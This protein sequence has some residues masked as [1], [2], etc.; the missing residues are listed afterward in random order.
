MFTPSFDQKGKIFTEVISKKP[1]QVFI[2]TEKHIIIG[3]I[4]I[5]PDDRLKDEIN[6]NEQFLAVTNAVIKDFE[7]NTQFKT[8]FVAVNRQHVSWVLP[9]DE[10]TDTT[11]KSWINEIEG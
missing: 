7:G 5:R 1:V 11:V 8:N 3:E 4:N 6:N 10:I 2:Y 9:I